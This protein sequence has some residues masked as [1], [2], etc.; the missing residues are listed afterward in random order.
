ML[1]HNGTYYALLAI[2]SFREEADT[3]RKAGRTDGCKQAR[4]DARELD[5]AL[6]R[7][8]TWEHQETCG[9]DFYR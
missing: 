5:R 7:I 1:K 6:E 3:H 2:R 9:L 4:K 8:S